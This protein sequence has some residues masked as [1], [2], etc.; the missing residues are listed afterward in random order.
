MPIEF[1]L[2]VVAGVAGGIVN[3]A[4]G[5]AKLFVFP[6]LLASGLPPLVANATG[7]LALW[8]AQG[9]AAWV[10]RDVLRENPRRLLGRLLPAL[11][12]SLAGAAA[13]IVS[14]ESAFTALIPLL[15]VLS[16]GAILLGPRVAELLQRLVPPARLE[17]VTG[18]LLF[19]AGFYGGYFGAGLGFMLL[20]VLTAAGLA[21][22]QRANG[23]K[24]LFVFC[25]NGCAALPLALSGLVD[26]VAAG[27]VLLGGLVGGYLGARVAKR[28]PARPLRWI[29]VVLGVVLTVS[30]LIR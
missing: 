20:A 30:F 29:V 15:L 27:G 14:S 8:P 2:F 24:I 26:W 17:A 16:V 10:Y 1:L 11:I 3:A 4:A 7:T 9:T 25:I 13:L 5:G 6:L 22:L 28:L 18:L 19:G 21:D 23:T 12:G